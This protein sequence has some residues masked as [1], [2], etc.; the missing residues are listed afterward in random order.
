MPAV[1]DGCARAAANRTAVPNDAA[2]DL[3]PHSQ[4]VAHLRVVRLRLGRRHY[5]REARAGRHAERGRREE[6]YKQARRGGRRAEREGE[7]EDEQVGHQCHSFVE[8]A[9]DR[10]TR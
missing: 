3:R 7:E 10:L 2:R 9:V 4:P 8:A 1:S 6:V 5:P